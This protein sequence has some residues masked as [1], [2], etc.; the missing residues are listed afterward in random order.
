M[1]QLLPYG[2]ARQSAVALVGRNPETNADMRPYL[3]TAN[4]NFRRA[5][6]VDPDWWATRGATLQV[7]WDEGRKQAPLTP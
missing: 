1:A 6:A 2:P 7:R 5:L 4:Y 3:P